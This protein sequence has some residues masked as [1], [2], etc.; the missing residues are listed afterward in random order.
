MADK[1]REETQ[2]TN[3]EIKGEDQMTGD[4]G[5]TPGQAEGDERTVEES[6]KHKEATQG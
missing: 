6:L 2:S 3:S 5:R 1:K 4:P